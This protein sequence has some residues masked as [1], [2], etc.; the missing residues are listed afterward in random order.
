VYAVCLRMTGDPTRAER[1]T[2]DAFVK[3][4]QTLAS[5]RGDSAFS[6]WMHRLAVN[7]V[8]MDVRATRRREQRVEPARDLSHLDAAARPCDSEAAIDLE[9]AIAELP[10]RAR[11]ILVLYDIEGYDQQEIAAMMDIA[12]GTVKAQLHRARHLL[13]ARLTR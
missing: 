4:W 8:L 3:A 13:R 6:T 12:V 5:F 1:L 9:R 7:T 11:R 10:D 2:Q